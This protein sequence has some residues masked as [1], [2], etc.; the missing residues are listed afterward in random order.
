MYHRAAPA[1]ARPSISLS[2]DVVSHMGLAAVHEPPGVAGADERCNGICFSGDFM[3]SSHNDGSVHV[4]SAVTGAQVQEV[5]VKDQG[6][7]LVT[8]THHPLG[9]LHAASK[10]GSLEMQGRVAYH[11]LHDNRILRVFDGHN[12]FVTSCSMN[13]INDTFV[14]AS[15]DGT[16]RIWDLRQRQAVA[17]G[18]LGARGLAAAAFDSSGEVIA[19]AAP[20]RMLSL[21]N[22]K[23]MTAF[24]VTKEPLMQQ[25]VTPG[26]YPPGPAGT[27]VPGMAVAPATAAAG[28]AAAAVGRGANLAPLPPSVAWTGMEFSPDDR[29]LAIATG[30]RGILVVDAF[31]PGRELALLQ[32]HPY[33]AVHPSNV[34]W[35][36]DGRHLATGA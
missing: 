14:T 2:A 20:N 21:L 4:F 34:S 24:T 16:F 5:H 6:C 25:T 26:K 27:A 10:G 17:S 18:E 11:S 12:D 30:D 13:P 36:P 31:F 7:R 35:S 3:I 28:M 32:Y 15:R 29:Y 33:D 8:P 22:A 23:T 1:A 19:V 9:V